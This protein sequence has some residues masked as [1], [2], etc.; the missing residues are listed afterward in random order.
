M[1][2]DDYQFFLN[3]SLI[4]A[5]GLKK[6]QI[7]DES[8][9]YLKKDPRYLYVFDEERISEVTMP[10]WIK[11]RMINGYFRGRS[12]EIGV[13]T[14]PQVFG[15]KDSPTYKGTQHGQPFPYDTHIPFLLYGWNVK[16]GATTQE[17]YI[18]DI[19]PTVC[20]MLHIQMPNGC[21]GTARNMALGN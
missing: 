19:A 15:A 20:A 11:E 9:E 14:R 10:Q 8:V 5:S 6:Q 2:E 17:T 7:I 1:A 13:V 3:D 18:V 21:I 16:H 12:G 4:A